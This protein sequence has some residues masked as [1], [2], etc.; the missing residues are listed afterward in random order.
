MKKNERMIFM[1]SSEMFTTAKWC[2]FDENI[3][4]PYVRKNFDVEKKEKAVIRICGLGFFE[5]YINSVKVSDDLLVPA[6]T[7]YHDRDLSPRYDLMGRMGHHTFVMEYDVTDYLREGRNAIGIR[8]GKG[9]YDW[10]DHYLSYGKMKLCFDLKIGDKHI[11]SD[12]E[13]KYI[14]SDITY[15]NIY[16]GERIDASLRRD[17]FASVSCDDSDWNR[18]IIIDAPDTDYQIQTAPADKIIRKIK[19]ILLSDNGTYS[20]Y[21]VTEAISGTV[22]VRCTQENSAITVRFADAL[23]EEGG[24]DFEPTGSRIQRDIIKNAKVGDTFCAKFCWHAF[25]YIEIS[26]NAEIVSVNVIHSDVAVTSGFECD[27]AVLNWL[28]RTYVRTQLD[29]MHCSIPSDCPHIERHGYTGDGQLCAP[30]VMELFDS[31]EFYKKWMQDIADCQE[32]D[33]GHVQHTAPFVNAGGG[34]AGWGGAIINVPYYYY[35]AFGD[36]DIPEKYF[37]NML[38]FVDYMVSRSENGLAWLEENDWC[39]GDWCAPVEYQLPEPEVISRVLIPESYVN[40]ALFVKQLENMK[41]MALAIGREDEIP[42][43]DEIMEKCRGAIT[44]AYYSP[45]TKD[46]CGNVQGANG[47]AVDIG[48]G[49]ED[50]IKSTC[51]KYR[52]TGEFDTGIFGTDIIP[53]ILFENGAEQTAFDMLSSRGNIS[54]GHMMENGATTLWE[55]W[56]PQRSLNHPMF[57]ACTR[58]LFE[59]IL[60]IRQTKDSIGYEKVIIEPKIVKGLDNAKGYITTVKGKIEVS[61][62]VWEGYDESRITVTIPEN[63]DATLIFMGQ[64][65]PLTAGENRIKV[66]H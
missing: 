2:G 39:L 4:S 36:K 29:N 34:P 16:S 5:L 42:A 32:K 19:P 65:Y 53:R 61:Y 26:D 20:I 47:F 21:D 56:H 15:T 10:N 38:K 24:L 43:L 57:G 49:G 27:N 3:G 63:M 50:T 11:V 46:F 1:K 55:D 33:T 12:E 48:L 64:T 14:Q 18:V 25:R 59:Y 22:T 28:Y 60:G 41:E 35:K 51:E 52:K 45:M 31:R 37:S 66:K 9:W 44:V 13:L 30:A 17:D 8:L 62:D 40:T 54:F 6:Y 23:K 7:Q 58:Y